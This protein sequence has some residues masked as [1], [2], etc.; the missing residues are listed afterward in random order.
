[1]LTLQNFY[2]VTKILARVKKWSGR[3]TFTE[4][5]KIGPVQS[6]M[7]WSR[8]LYSIAASDVNPH[9][10]SVQILIGL[11]NWLSSQ[12][13]ILPSLTELQNLHAMACSTSN[14]KTRRVQLKPLFLPVSHFEAVAGQVSLI[15]I[16]MNSFLACFKLTDRQA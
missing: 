12:S 4:S 5:P 7:V 8:K 14:K 13:I 9:S 15:I 3:T 1:M 11:H 6:K 10:R 2:P 16:A